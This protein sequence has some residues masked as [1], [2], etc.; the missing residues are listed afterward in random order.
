LKYVL[1][2]IPVPERL[3][4]DPTSLAEWLFEFFEVTIEELGRKEIEPR[5]RQA[6]HLILFDGIM[7]GSGPAYYLQQY[8]WSAARAEDIA[9]AYRE[10]GCALCASALEAVGD[11]PTAEALLGVAEQRNC[12]VGE[13]IGAHLRKRGLTMPV[14]EAAFEKIV[15]KILSKS[16][17][18]RAR[19]RRREAETEKFRAAMREQHRIVLELSGRAGLAVRLSQCW[20]GA[21]K[22]GE[23]SADCNVYHI[24]DSSSEPPK[25]TPDQ[26]AYFED[27][28][29]G[30]LA[31][32]PD[33]PRL[34]ECVIEPGA[35]LYRPKY[36]R[37]RLEE[38]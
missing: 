14:R 22:D 36:P 2:R 24:L 20:Q 21:W 38:E 7:Q 17:V 18:H 1:D 31:R 11:H 29:R 5:C 15:S 27:N 16:A 34:A 25:V 35:T 33:G 6:A 23:F 37:G 8:G 3:L 32:Y 12:N 4:S 26:V 30:V 28:D 10:I 13:A 19:E 9:S